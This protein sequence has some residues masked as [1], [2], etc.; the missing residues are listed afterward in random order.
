[1]YYTDD[2]VADAERYIAEQDRRY[3]ALPRCCRC[4]ERFS[5]EE[6][7]DINGFNYCTYCAKEF[8]EEVEQYA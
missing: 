3:R 1:M 2:P 6:I 5:E 7:E 4:G 8:Y